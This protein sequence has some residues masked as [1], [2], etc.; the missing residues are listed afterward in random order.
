[1]MDYQ[2]L[3]NSVMDELEK[4]IAPSTFEDTF[5]EVKK[6]AKAENGVIFVV[7]PSN[8][9]KRKINTIYYRSIDEIV[10]RVSKQNIKVTFVLQE[11]VKPY[12]KKEVKEPVILNN[13]NYLNPNYTFESFVVVDSNRIAYLAALLLVDSDNISLNNASS[14]EMILNP[15]Y[16]F[17]GVGLGK[18]HLM[19]AIGNYV[20]NKNVDNK[21]VYVS[22][23]EFLDDYAKASYEKNMK[24]FDDKY[25]N[26]DYLLIDDIQMLADKT[27]TQQQFFKIF[28]DMDNKNKQIIITSDR[29]ASS[30]NGFMDRLTSRFQKG[31]TVNINVPDLNQRISILKRKVSE[32]TPE[33]L[34]QD[35]LVYIAEN[36]ANNIR[37]LEGALNRVLLLSKLYNRKPDLSLTKEA[38][39]PLMSTKV[40]K[41]ENSY[42][43]LLSVI[44]GM[45]NVSLAD[46]LSTSRNA[47]YVY[48]RHIAMYIMKNKYNLTNKEIGN[49]FNGRDHSTVMHACNKIADDLKVNKELRNMVDAILKK[50]E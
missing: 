36:F 48:P 26:I 1:M 38:L 6:V 35:V 13:N 46:L 9:I 50:C 8:L 20:A 23:N 41:D 29:P 39:E 30:L 11:E 21:I 19:Q 15:F 42:E 4:S 34:S 49:I 28:N 40:K 3:W 14:R 12:Y 45:Y 22:A 10:K 37:E 18:T 33:E 17:G 47:N 7:C 5:A 27:A 32:S 31:T 25:N 2:A 24:A 16:I 43:N 44:S